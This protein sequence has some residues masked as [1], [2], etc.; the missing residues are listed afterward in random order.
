MTIPE[1]KNELEKFT[2]FK[3]GLK[4]ELVKLDSKTKHPVKKIVSNKEIYERV[5]L[6][7]SS[8]RAYR[9]GCAHS[10]SNL[11]FNQ[12]V[13]SIQIDN[14]EIKRILNEINQV[15]SKIYLL[16]HEKGNLEKEFAICLEN[17]SNSI[18][19]IESSINSCKTT[20][21]NYMNDLHLLKTAL[22]SFI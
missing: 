15:I 5:A 20:H 4:H 18:V 11:K 2:V 1:I 10:N 17:P 14:L 8:K 16:D 19:E 13:S 3:C 9:L 21:N 22:L 7:N 12:L 6:C